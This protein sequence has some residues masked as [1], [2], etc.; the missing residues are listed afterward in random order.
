MRHRH[1]RIQFQPVVSGRTGFLASHTLS[2]SLPSPPAAAAAAEKS[3]YRR[4]YAR[5]LPPFRLAGFAG[6]MLVLSI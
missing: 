2:P 4:C 1:R 3:G 5:R 6:V